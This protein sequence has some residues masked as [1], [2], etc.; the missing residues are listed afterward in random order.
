[1][2]DDDRNVPLPGRDPAPD[3]IADPN[4]GVSVDEDSDTVT[5][6]DES[7]VG[8]GAGEKPIVKVTAPVEHE[9]DDPTHY[10]T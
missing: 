10:P 9:G 7:G 8:S 2:A 5:K 6:S 1:M 3:D 4:A